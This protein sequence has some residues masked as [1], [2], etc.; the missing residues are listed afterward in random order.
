[1]AHWMIIGLLDAW[2]IQPFNLQSC[3]IELNE[4]VGE[5]EREFIS[6]LS[7]NDRMHSIC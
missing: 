7:T 5:K 1:M 3:F 2:I 4:L 6:W